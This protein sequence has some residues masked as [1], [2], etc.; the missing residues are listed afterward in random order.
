[1]FNIQNKQRCIL[2]TRIDFS[3]PLPVI[4]RNGRILEPDDGDGHIILGSGDAMML[5]CENGGT[6]VHPNTKSQRETALIYCEVNHYFKNEDWLNAPS[7]FSNFR[8][9]NPPNYHSKRTD[10]ICFEGNPV[11]EVGYT[12]LNDF[13][14]VFES[15]FDEVN[16]NAIYSKYTQK[17]YN[18]MYQTRV[19]R[20]FFIDNNNYRNISVDL[21]FSPRGQKAAVAQ[22]VGPLVNSYITTSSLLSRGH[23]AAKTDFVFAFTERA[24]FHYVNCAPQWT[25]FNGGNWN[26]LEVDL[27]N[28]I[29]AV[30][31]DTIIYTGTYGVSQLVDNY[32]RRVDL[33]LYTDHNNNPIIRIPQYFYKVV[34][35]PRTKR[36]IAYVGINNPYY[37]LSEARDLFFCEDICRNTSGFS[38]LTWHPDNPMEGYTFCCTVPSFKNTV[39]HL[40]PFEVNGLL[41]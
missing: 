2:N 25:G 9:N 5:S 26:T 22:L 15:C 24:T 30:G 14:P 41:I 20:P 16:F 23:L 31:Y 39:H 28:H 13:Y 17:P 29:H 19:E 37:T 27:R 8:C 4:L 12:V 40:P 35:E 38:W 7:S 10:R 36:G 21:L 11:I 1:M 33:H 6:L 3:Q 32:G 18:A 34:Y